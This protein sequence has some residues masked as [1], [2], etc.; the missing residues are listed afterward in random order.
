LARCIF[1]LSTTPA[2]YVARFLVLIRVMS[3]GF[4]CFF[5]FR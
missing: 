2:C 3:L 1:S 5:S 4:L